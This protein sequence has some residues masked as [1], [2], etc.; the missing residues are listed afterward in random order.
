MRYKFYHIPAMCVAK[1]KHCE[2][3]PP[4]SPFCKGGSRMEFGKSIRHGIFTPPLQKGEAPRSSGWAGLGEDFLLGFV[5]PYRTYR[6]FGVSG[7]H[8]KACRMVALI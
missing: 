6:Q 8:P 5:T 2:E 4:Q 7:Y 3:N 1:L